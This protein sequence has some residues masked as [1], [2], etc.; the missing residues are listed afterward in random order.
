[1]AVKHIIQPK[2]EKEAI[3]YVNGIAYS[4]IPHWFGA[5]AR[6]L[7]MD[8]LLPKYWADKQE[9][10]PVIVWICGGSFKEMDRSVWLPDL[11]PLAQ[12]G[13]AIA[14]IEYRTSNETSFPD[15][16]I[17]VKTAIRFLKAN[18]D[19]FG[20][21]R[22]RICV[23]GESA[24]AILASL[25]GVTAGLAEFESGEYASWDSGVKAVVAFYGKYDFSLE[26]NR[27]MDPRY[28]PSWTNQAFLGSAYPNGDRASSIRY[29]NQDTP[30]FLLL[31]GDGDELVACEQ[32]EVMHEAMV[33]RG[34]DC[35]LYIIA[36]AGHG[37]PVFY[38][39]EVMDVIDQFLRRVL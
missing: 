38:Q 18:A 34:L 4:V 10:R 28:V 26:D 25:A 11:M 3:A 31:H 8:L 17:D 23:M 2:M 12:M 7:K 22:E 33:S 15:P 6:N 24:G 13:Y 21:D 19:R 32:S 14:S 35:T 39:P 37:E 36:G 5:T 16:L 27:S 20:L 30:P 1:M 9:K 29:L